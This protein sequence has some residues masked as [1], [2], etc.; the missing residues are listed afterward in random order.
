MAFARVV[1]FDG[2]GKDRIEEM[3]KDMDGDPPRGCPP[4]R[5]SCSTMRRPRSRS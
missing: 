4:K 5:S 3:R 1:T 2:V